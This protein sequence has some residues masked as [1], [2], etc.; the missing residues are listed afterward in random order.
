M[1]EFIP[2]ISII[3]PVYNSQDYLEKALNTISEQNNSKIEVLLIDD[4][5]TDSSEQICRK[6]CSKYPYFRYYRKLNGGLC[7]AR[8]YGL[9]KVSGT[10]IMF[11]DN[12]DELPKGAI[13]YISDCLE[14]YNCDIYRFN[15]KRI[16]IFKD[17]KQ[18]IDIY[19]TRGI[20]NSINRELIM[21]RT[22]FFRHYDICRKSGCFSGIWN[23]VYKKSLFDGV[24]FDTD[25]T[26]GGEDWLM[27]LELYNR[28]SK[29]YFSN[30]ITYCY[31]R[32]VSHS[33]STTYQDNRIQA[34][35]KCM[36]KEY[37]L[38]EDNNVNKVNVLKSG[39]MYIGQIIKVLM[40][41]NSDKNLIQK[42]NILKKMRE[43]DIFH[44]D[45]LF[46]LS[47]QLSITERVFIALFHKRKYYMLI[48]I[49]EIILKLRGNT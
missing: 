2:L 28:F 4:G 7:S 6:Y 19:G 47:N 14:K 31:F 11:M 8:N 1:G 33:I 29:I 39:I 17:N 43:S 32:R 44:T 37:Q 36:D 16:Q 5:S 10:Y 15:R 40:H 9:S 42:R 49:S 41:K 3:I 48:I 38:I 13:N 27:N 35:V 22:E 23:G 34:I 46:Y 25:I 12:D 26:A 18:K 21:S 30:Y 20:T 45:E 24:L